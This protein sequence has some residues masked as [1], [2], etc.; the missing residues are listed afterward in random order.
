MAKH[1]CQ[2]EPPVRAPSVIFFPG[3]TLTYI[4]SPL[5]DHSLLGYSHELVCSQ[6]FL[7]WGEKRIL[8]LRDIQ[9]R[10]RV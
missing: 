6:C 10:G 9:D 5:W 8:E 4:A 3:R 7:L 2:A 1:D